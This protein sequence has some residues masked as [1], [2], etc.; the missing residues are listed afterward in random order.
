MINK[1]VF[2]GVAIFILLVVFV[3]F[4]YLFDSDEDVSIGDVGLDEG[5]RICLESSLVDALRIVGLQGGYVVV[6]DKGF[7]FEGMRIAYGFY[8]GK[9]SFPRLKDIESEVSSYVEAIAPICIEN[10]ESYNVVV[11][12]LVSDVSFEEGLVDM[13]AEVKVDDGMVGRYSLEYDLDMKGIVE[14]AGDIVRQLEADS[15]GV[16]LIDVDGDYDVVALERDRNYVYIISN[17]NVE[18]PFV[19]R[20]AV[21]YGE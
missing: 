3:V 18:G 4:F 15:D 1:R 8:D 2:F 6:S 10:V 11:S 17:K 12:D 9:G 21:K 13:D 20:F 7:D 16:P 14:F 19:F 5:I